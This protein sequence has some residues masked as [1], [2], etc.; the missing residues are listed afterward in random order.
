VLLKKLPHPIP[1]PQ[2]G[3]E[4][5]FFIA[6]LRFNVGAKL[7][8]LSLIGRGVGVRVNKRALYITPLSQL[9]MIS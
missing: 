2:L 3:G 9:R 1:L 8:P 7:M 5:I 6:L 4:G